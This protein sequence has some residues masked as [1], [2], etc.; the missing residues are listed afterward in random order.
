MEIKLGK[1]LTVLISVEFFLVLAIIAMSSS[2]S[3]RLATAYVVRESEAAQKQ[4]FKILT[5]AVCE[6]ESGNVAC[7]D[8]L[9]VQCNGKEYLVKDGAYAVCDNTRL[10]LSGLAANGS[11]KFRKLK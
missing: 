2:E 5:R 3:K 8:R 11:A 10:D 1:I 4:D 9:F 6:E 7:H